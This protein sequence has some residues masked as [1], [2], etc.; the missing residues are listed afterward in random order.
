MDAR[1]P[2]PAQ[3]TRA[4]PQFVEDFDLVMKA[5]KVPAKDVDI[6]KM[7]CRADMAAAAE[8]LAETAHLIRW[9]WK[10]CP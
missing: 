1:T 2:D 4:S 6:A 9:G 7:V 5:F 10:P 3:R 8:S